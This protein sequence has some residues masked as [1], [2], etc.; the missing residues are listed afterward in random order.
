MNA[1]KLG[2]P[3]L[4]GAPEILDAIDVVRS[5]RGFV[6]AM[7]DATMLLVAKVHKTS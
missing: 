4:V 3:S 7:M 6:F 1:S 5:I 2:K